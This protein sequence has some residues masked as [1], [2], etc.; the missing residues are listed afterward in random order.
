MIKVILSTLTAVR[1]SLPANLRGL[2]SETL[3]NLQTQ[4]PVPLPVEFKDIEYWPENHI[5]VDYDP[6][7]EKLEGE[8]LTAD[9]A[10]KVVNVEALA[11]PYTPP[12]VYLTSLSRTDFKGMFTATEYRAISDMSKTDDN[13]YQFWD[14]AQTADSINMEDTRTIQGVSY[15]A[16]VGIFDEAR[17]DEILM[18]KL[19]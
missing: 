16:F 13:L 2:S 1:E 7:T 14:M 15:L 8:T 10:N 19:Q 11:V 9:E 4:G 6:L 12:I 5:A 3:R 18:G 17:R